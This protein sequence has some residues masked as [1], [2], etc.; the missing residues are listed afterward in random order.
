[1]I[2]FRF[3]LAINTSLGQINLRRNYTYTYIHTCTC[4]TYMLLFDRCV[5]LI[6]RWVPL[7][8]VQVREWAEAEKAAVEAWCA[9]QRQASAREKRAALK[10]VRVKR[11]GCGGEGRSVKGEA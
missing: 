4:I 9:E 8:L 2:T 3:R 7:S 6:G 11:E 1:M 5:D 10:Q